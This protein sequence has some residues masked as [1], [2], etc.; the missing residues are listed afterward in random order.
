MKVININEINKISN[1]Q[2]IDIREKKEVQINKIDGSKN[3]PMTGLILNPNM[4]LDKETTYYLYCNTGARSYKTC[5]FLDG[6]GYNVV[7]LSG[8]ISNYKNN[9][10]L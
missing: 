4:F 10:I 1:A 7:D 8:G 2:I 5:Q 9:E 6:L 3:I